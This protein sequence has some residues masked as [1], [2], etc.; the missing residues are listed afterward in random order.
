MVFFAMFLGLIWGILWA[1]FLQRHPMGQFLA[2]KRTWVTV[3]IGVGVDLLI[4][5]LVLDLAAWL[6]VL[7]IIGFSSLGIIT[8][9]LHNE[10]VEI[11]GILDE[12]TKA[13]SE[14]EG[15]E[16]GDLGAGGY[17][18]SVSSSTARMGKGDGSRRGANGCADVAASGQDT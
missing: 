16:Q 12:F 3:V 8:R 15:S 4:C 9:S 17:H 14:Q 18:C 6:L 2:V 1:I 13:G 7:A 10:R 5:L 11:W